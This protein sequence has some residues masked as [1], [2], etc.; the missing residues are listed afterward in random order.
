MN[1]DD[2]L[3]DDLASIHETLTRALVNIGMKVGAS[4]PDFARVC[5]ELDTLGDLLSRL[6]RVEGSH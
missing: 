4:D 6:Q 1:D 5:A 3:V 2:A